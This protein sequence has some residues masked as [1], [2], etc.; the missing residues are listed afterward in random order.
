MNY[1]RFKH[2]LAR[3]P[4]F[5]LA[6]IR[7]VD[8]RF[9]RRRLTEWQHKGYIKKIIKGYYLFADADINEK[10]LFEIANKIY[11]PSY[12]SLESALSYYHLIPESVFAITSV[13]TRRTHRFETGIGRFIFRTIQPKLF[14]G[15]VVTP[16]FVK[17]AYMEKA[18]LDYFYLNSSLR[19]VDDFKSLRL[20]RE[21]LLEQ[22]RE[23]RLFNFLKRIN[24]H[25]LTLR[26][27][28]FMKWIQNA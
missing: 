25:T 15:Y 2:E 10:R 3:F 19:S 11:R 24:Q 28:Q 16:D 23:E 22:L 14:F 7:A 17:I 4:V 1:I 21:V 27:T 8:P 6:D 20:N 9:D 18:L 26:I 12:V 5:S 13:S